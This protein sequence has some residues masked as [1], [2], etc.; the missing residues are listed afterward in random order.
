MPRSHSAMDQ[1]RAVSA[2][3]GKRP[4]RPMVKSHARPRGWSLV[5][6]DDREDFRTALRDY[7]RT[8]AFL[9]QVVP[10]TSPDLEELFY[11]GKV[12]SA[13]LPKTVDEDGDVDISDI[14]VLTHIRTQM[15]GEHDLALSEGD[16]VG[17]PGMAGGGSGA[18][19]VK[20]KVRLSTL[21]DLLNDRFGTEFTEI[22]QVLWDQQVAAAA[23]DPELVEVAKG[24]SEENFG[25]VFDPKFGDVIID[26][27]TAN[28]ELFRMFFDK[29]E[30]REVL[31]AWARRKV[32][33]AIQDGLKGVA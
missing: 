16:G 22:D 24:N 27:Q 30:F 7:V 9:G 32:Y 8:Y 3:L 26:R 15:S 1:P 29:P 12:L 5:E 28:D 20:D 18:Q 6:L 19:T 2:G 4:I 33:E 14:A 25:F 21:I 31:T 17:V 23:A 11:Y 13:R 10:F